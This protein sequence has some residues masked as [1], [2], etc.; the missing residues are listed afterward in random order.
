VVERAFEPFFT[1]KEVGKGTGLGL[2]QVYGTLRQSG[3]AAR[4]ESSPGVG[5]VV[6]LFLR[7]TEAMPRKREE[8]SGKPRG[9]AATILVVDDDPDV[10]AFLT[11]SLDSLGYAAVVAESGSVALQTLERISPEVVILDFAMPGMN[12]AELARRIRQLQPEL[13]IIFAS[14]YSETAAIK[15]VTGDRSRVLHKPFKVH[16]LQAALGELLARG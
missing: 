9:P 14:G 11:E 16:E 2:S 12:G 7:R 5:T 15:S 3:G 10:R 13:P 4:I 6:R 8:S 1:T